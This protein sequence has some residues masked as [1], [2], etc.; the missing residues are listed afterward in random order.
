[1]MNKNDPFTFE[2]LVIS[3][4]DKWG[5]LQLTIEDIGVY[6]TISVDGSIELNKD[7]VIKLIEFLQLQLDNIDDENLQTQKEDR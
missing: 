7:Q 2:K 3:P 1:M 5:D 4:I 6:S